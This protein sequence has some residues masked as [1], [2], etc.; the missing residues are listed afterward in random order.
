MYH[1]NLV[2]FPRSEPGW[3]GTPVLRLP[4]AAARSQPVPPCSAYSRPNRGVFGKAPPGIRE[5][6]EHSW[7]SAVLDLSLVLSIDFRRPTT[8]NHNPQGPDTSFWP[9]WTPSN[10]CCCLRSMYLQA[11][12]YT[13]I[14]KSSY[15]GCPQTKDSDKGAEQTVWL[16]ECSS[17][18]HKTVGSIPSRAETQVWQCAPRVQHRGAQK[19]RVRSSGLEEIGSMG[20]HSLENVWK[21]NK[22]CLSPSLDHRW[23]KPKLP[24]PPAL[25]AQ[26]FWQRLCSHHSNWKSLF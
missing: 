14:E 13:Q 8:T 25:P 17:R 9:P 19:R 15:K 16:V 3:P 7:I 23:S 1:L 21:Q 22:R 2:W 20:L 4:T 5:T 11:H 6:A 24:S 18:I 26:Q 12:I 10:V